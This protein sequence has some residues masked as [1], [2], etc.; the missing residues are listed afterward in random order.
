MPIIGLN[1]TKINAERKSVKKVTGI[2]I[3]T[4][5]KITDVKKTTLVGLGK[6]A[7]ALTIGFEIESKFDPA[8]GNIEI[9]GN[10][11]YST[12]NS[13]KILSS[14][15]KDKTLP[16][17]NHIEVLNHIFRKTTVQA[18]QLADILQLPPPLNL[19]RIRE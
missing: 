14:W 13:K 11:L 15:K 5:P 19:P 4:V 7:E 8:I 6:G 18:L 16:K 10:L 1:Y 17:E 12:N 9:V 2:K 3:N